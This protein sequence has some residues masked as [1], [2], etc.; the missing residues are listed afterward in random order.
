MN[1]P[2]RAYLI[3][4]QKAGTT[5]LAFLLD[6][7]PDVHLSR[8]KE[9][10][11]FTGRWDQGLDWY[12]GCFAGA[13]PGSVLLDA[14]ADY[15]MA[16]LAPD[17]S[18]DASAGSAMAR[19]PERIRAVRP[20]ARFIYVLR[21][22]VSRAYS[23]YWHAV[24]GGHESRGFRDVVT[25]DSI[26]VRGSRYYRQLLHFLE[27]FQLTDFLF[28]DFRELTR[29]PRGVARRGIDFLGLEPGPWE[30]RL[31]HAKNESYQFTSAGRGMRRLAG[32]MRAIE[33]MNARFGGLVPERARALAKGLLTRRVPPMSEAD[34]DWLRPLFH[35]EYEH[36]EALTGI[37]FG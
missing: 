23:S 24:R 22:P 1:F 14:T 31:E 2:P 26:Y 16:P 10:F 34:R 13:G 5:T 11:F 30:P 6:Q 20:D 33:A 28:V 37:R 35:E 9:P 19:V 8:P 4:A 15:A 27:H 36:I 29:D 21:D 12:R 32:G 17:G 3:G 25:P 18:V 7:H